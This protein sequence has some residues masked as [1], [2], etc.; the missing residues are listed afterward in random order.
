MSHITRKI[1]LGIV[2]F[3]SLAGFQT[4]ARASETELAFS[5][6]FKNI[7]KPIVVS[8]YYKDGGVWAMGDNAEMDALKT[9]L[10][11]EPATQT[12]TVNYSVNGDMY[13]ASSVL[14]GHTFESLE[15]S[16][17]LKITAPSTGI[18]YEVVCVR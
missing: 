10:E 2:L 8:V 5:C 3:T 15:G 4:T 9:D 1:F 11:Y 6:S 13:S 17:A 12:V 7:A 18:H 14:K 16:V